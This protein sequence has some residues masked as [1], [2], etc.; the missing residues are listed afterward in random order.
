MATDVW[1][2]AN[3]GGALRYGLKRLSGDLRGRQSPPWMLQVILLLQQ[4]SAAPPQP[5][6]LA[7]ALTDYIYISCYDRKYDY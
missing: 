5:P 6:A 2:H 4:L 3:L 7:Q 1:R